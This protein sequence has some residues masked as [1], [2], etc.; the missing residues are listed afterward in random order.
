MSLFDLESLYKEVIMDHSKSPRNKK[1]LAEADHRVELL[2]PTCGDAVI[3]EFTVEDDK[4]QDIA[5]SG[6][7]CA[8]SMASADMMCETLKNKSTDDAVGI[9]ANFA[10]L[11]GGEIDSTKQ[12]VM[13]EKELK[14][15]L[16]DAY[17]LE[18]VKKFPA[19]Y[20]C[21]ILAWRALEMGINQQLTL[22]DG[23]SVKD[24][25]N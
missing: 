22:E 24:T 15:V 3:V 9:I 10:H 23:I 5:F 12:Y 6:Q 11:I 7:G 20:K 8:I 21:G 25:E 14:T 1:E 2:N 17:F 19:R 4:I 18:G 13:N 16:Q